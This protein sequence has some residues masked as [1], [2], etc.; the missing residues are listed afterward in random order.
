[1]GGAPAATEEAQR[2][3][4]MTVSAATR[5]TLLFSTAGWTPLDWAGGQTWPATRRGGAWLSQP[6]ISG[7]LSTV[8]TTPCSILVRSP[9][10]REKALP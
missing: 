9:P 5:V 7:D 3:R 6:G 2:P 8:A 4:S 10:P 1:M